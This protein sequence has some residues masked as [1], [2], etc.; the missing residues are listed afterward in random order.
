MGTIIQVTDGAVDLA[1]TMDK[2]W[3]YGPLSYSSEYR[4]ASRPLCGPFSTKITVSDGTRV[5]GINIPHSGATPSV[6]LLFKDTPAMLILA[7]LGI[8]KVYFQGHYKSCTVNLSWP[9][10]DRTPSVP[11]PHKS[12]HVQSWPFKLI[13]DPVFDEGSGRIA[14][15][16]TK[17]GWKILEF[18]LYHRN[19]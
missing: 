6:H 17:H 13:G 5:F 8:N 11:L 14:S 16:T 10:E 18:N 12:F 9:D 1:S 4:H 7:R 3:K 19:E 2:V 15:F